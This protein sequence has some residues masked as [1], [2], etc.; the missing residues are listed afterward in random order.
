MSLL[1]NRINGILR[2]LSLGLLAASLL[3]FSG[4]L[5][6]DNGNIKIGLVNFKE[7]IEKS[8]LGKQE[9]EMYENMKKQIETILSEKEEEFQKIQKKLQ[10]EDFRDTQKPEALKKMQEQYQQLGT[11]LAQGQQQY[12]QA[13]QQANFK[14]L[15]RI[16]D[17]VSKASKKVA[18]DKGLDLILNDDNAFYNSPKL[19][20]TSAVITEMDNIAAEEL[21]NAA[22]SENP[23]NLDLKK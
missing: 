17:I 16:A 1:K 23:L 9:Q 15:Q 18:E 3:G 20:V 12:Y 13:L 2:C 8:K 5:S 4:V 22:N 19:D 6:A 14:I 11:E 10:D 21:K 7:A